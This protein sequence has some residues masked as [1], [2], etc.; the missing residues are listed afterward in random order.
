MV[1]E[2]SCPIMYGRALSSSRTLEKS[3]GTKAKVR[4]G[5]EILRGCQR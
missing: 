5:A 1:A 3:V 2:R 4:L